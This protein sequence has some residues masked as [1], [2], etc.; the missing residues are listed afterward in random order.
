LSS[1]NA[2][3]YVNAYSINDNKVK[4]IGVNKQLAIGGMLLWLLS[5]GGN[6][7]GETIIVSEYFPLD[8][9]NSWTHLVT[10]PEG[11][12]NQTITVL[13]GT[14]MINSV[15]TKAVKITGGPDGEGFEYWTNDIHGIRAH[16]AYLPGIG[17]VN[18]EPPLVNANRT[19][20]IGET[21]NSRG[22][23]RYVF[24]VYGTFILDYESTSTVERME[25]VTVPAGSYETLM[26]SSTDRMYG[27]L[28][29]E[30]YED[31]STGTTWLAKY[32]GEVKS[33][34]YDQDGREEDVLISTNVQP[35]VDLRGTIKTP[36]GTDICAMVLASGQYTFSC[37]PVGVFS[38]TGLPRET[39]GT[40]KCQM[41]ADGFFPEINILTESSSEAFVMPRSGTCPSYNIP[42]EPAFVPGS[43][44]KE[45]HIAGQVFLQNSVTPICAM[46]LANG[47]YMF[48]CDGTGSYFL[49]IPLDNNGQFKMQV[50]ADGFAPSIR[51]FDEFKTT[52][53]VRMARAAECQ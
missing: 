23:A 53:I 48:S 52:N 9:G 16:G 17:W 15:E 45:I 5:Q 26:I 1:I 18:L 46:V 6:I 13:P 38:L 24:D 21:V 28:G 19:M 12:Y 2:S 14:T 44:G 32:I 47:Q 20:N 10:G 33:I 29:G 27:Y 37:N 41:Y 42:Y 31:P 30:W 40:V 39:D 43:A 4:R 49:K 7:F 11:T 25:T 50:Y 35:P 34:D 8:D 36:D 51:K 22:K 3:I